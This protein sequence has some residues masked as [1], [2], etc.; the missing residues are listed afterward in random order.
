MQPTKEPE[1][2]TLTA[3]HR[4]R[5]LR[6]VNESS[7]LASCERLGLAREVVARLIGGLPVRRAT[8][9][10]AT[11]AIAALDVA[12]PHQRICASASDTERARRIHAVNAGPAALRA[13][14][15]SRDR[16]SWF[17]AWATKN[18]NTEQRADF[19]RELAKHAK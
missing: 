15:G 3:A 6:L 14:A 16:P 4:A 5:L 13:A 18:L 11:A 8:L 17:D 7:L 10:V 2:L 12:A 19:E 1:P 9:I